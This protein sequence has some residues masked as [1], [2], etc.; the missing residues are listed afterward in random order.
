MRL[1]V[2]P[3]ER[4]AGLAGDD[5]RRD[6]HGPDAFL[7]IEL[8]EWRKQRS[9]L[10]VLDR[11]RLRKLDAGRSFGAQRDGAPAEL[12]GHARR[13]G[14]P[15]G[16]RHRVQAPHGAGVGVDQFA[17][18]LERPLERGVHGRESQQPVGGGDHQAQPLLEVALLLLDAFERARGAHLLADV[19][20]DV[21]RADH[22]AGP[23]EDRRHADRHGHQMPVLVLPHRFVVADRLAAADA[24]EHVLFLGVPVGR[25]HGHQR[26]ADHFA[27][28]VSEHP[29]GRAVPGGDDALEGLAGDRVLGRI[30]D[31]AEAVAGERAG[32]QGWGNRFVDGHATIRAAGAAVFGL[33]VAGGDGSSPRLDYTGL[34]LSGNSGRRG[35]EPRHGLGQALTERDGGLVAE[36][37]PRLGDVG[38]RIAHVARAAG[39]P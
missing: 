22:H 2:V 37:P 27:G 13:H 11:E 19:T 16:V 6:Q 4:A 18:Q 34:S 20:R 12:S 17:R 36:Q 7:A 8:D 33:S 35:P 1:A 39:G 38:L 30:D 9:A 25:H 5:E 24:G 15:P 3:D 10:D 29:L 23:V 31:G 21:G 32:R 26:A 28:G 14:D